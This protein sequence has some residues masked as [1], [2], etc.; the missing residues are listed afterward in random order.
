MNTCDVYLTNE[1]KPTCELRFIDGRLQQKWDVREGDKHTDQ[2]RF[3]PHVRL[4]YFGAE[5]YRP[6]PKK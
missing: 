3:V 1:E 4:D 5:P 6:E 2:W